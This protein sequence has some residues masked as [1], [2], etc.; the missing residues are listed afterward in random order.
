MSAP[1]NQSVAK[2][3]VVMMSAQIGAKILAFFL[4]F[5]QPESS[6]SISSV[7]MALRWRW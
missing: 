5:T 2:N 4:L 1:A 7:N 6:A 3:S